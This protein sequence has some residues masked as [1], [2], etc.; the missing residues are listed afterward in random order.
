MIIFQ[1]M[2]TFE[3][4]PADIV[5]WAL[6]I[7]DVVNKRTQLSTSLWEGLFGG[8]AGTLVWSALV[9]NLTALQAA[10]D[11][12]A[13]DAGYLSLV[14]KASGWTS[15]P[16]EDS[17]LRVAHTSGGDYVRPDVGAYAE[18]TAAV[19]AAGK[20]AKAGAFG[21]E[22]AVLHVAVRRVR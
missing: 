22:I 19:P 4:S 21:V 2:V 8:P 1:R 13:A 14:A 10:T 17:L 5:P 7:T 15:A 11:A 3:G 9:D 12:L 6:E 18:G 20:L 16:A